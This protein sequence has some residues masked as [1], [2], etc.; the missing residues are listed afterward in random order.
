MRDRIAGHSIEENKI[1]FR[2]IMIVMK[3]FHIFCKELLCRGA[4]NLNIINITQQALYETRAVDTLFI[5][6][7][8]FIRRFQPFVDK[9]IECG[10]GQTVGRNL[11]PRGK[12][13]NSFFFRTAIGHVRCRVGGFYNNSLILIGGFARTRTCRQECDKQNTGK[14]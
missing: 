8:I 3:R 13:V 10:I 12:L 5:D 2:K 11:H 9:G 1:A 4:G 7:S 14:I 6:A